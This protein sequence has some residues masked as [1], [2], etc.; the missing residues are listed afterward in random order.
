MRSALSIRRN[1]N[2]VF[3][4]DIGPVIMAVQ[5]WTNGNM[6]TPRYDFRLS[7]RVFVAVVLFIALSLPPSL[8]PLPKE[9]KE[10]KE[11]RGARSRHPS[12]RRPVHAR[13]HVH[14]SID[15]FCAVV[16]TTRLPVPKRKPDHHRN[17]PQRLCD[18]AEDDSRIVVIRRHLTTCGKSLR[19]DDIV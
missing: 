10:G 12:R 6:S 2:L 14:S 17:H 7:R 18:G 3:P 19:F 8:P 16:R 13:T 4:H 5:G 1:T 15:G 11:G 9:G